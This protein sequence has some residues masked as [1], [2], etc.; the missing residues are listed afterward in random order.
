MRVRHVLPLALLVLA[1]RASAQEEYANPHWSISI[2]DSGYSDIILYNA[3]PFPADWI[4]EMISG[5]WGAAVAYD[6]IP[7]ALP[8]RAMWLEP[9]WNY[10]TWTTNSSFT[11]VSPMSFPAD[12]DADGLPEG[13]SVIAN[14]DV[15]ITIALDMVDT[16]TGTPMGEGTGSVLSDRFVLVTTYT[17]KNLRATT[18]TGV[19]FFPF[20]HGHPANDEE[21]SVRA[22]YDTTAYTGALQTYRYDVTERATNSGA[23]DESPTGCMFQDRIGFSTEVAPADFGLGPYRGHVDRPATGLHVDVEQDI[24]GNQT[25][26]GP[27]EVA[28]A[29]RIDLGSIASGASKSVQVL[30]AVRS[31]DIS[32]NQVASTSCVRITPGAGSDPVIFLD[33]GAC[34]TPSPSATA[35]NVVAGNL[36]GLV[37]TGGIVTL[38]PVECIASKIL[39]DRVT[40]STV[41]SDCRKAVFILAR[42]AMP[43]GFYGTSSS[44]SLR[45]AA[46]GDCP[47]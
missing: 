44:G 7:L 32:P 20:L 2:T 12:L 11:V 27:D 16:V 29:T 9:E 33:K 30:L 35:W 18:L 34:A 4:H 38:G 45:F 42:E 25:T 36:S 8:V 22:F 28:G 43:F 17:I 5:E 1:P 24:L 3:G 15:E 26:F 41:L 21:P 23:T 31:D 14:G 47:P 39:V 13:S 6:G 37:E 46:T 10:P 40:E 19:R